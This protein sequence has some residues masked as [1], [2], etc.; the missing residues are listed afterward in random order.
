[1]H[2]QL[3]CK[4]NNITSSYWVWCFH[5]Q[6]G[7]LNSLTCRHLPAQIQLQKYQ[8]KVFNLFKANNKDTRTTSVRSGI[9]LVNF[10][11]ISKFFL[12]FLLLNLNRLR[13]NRVF[14]LLVSFLTLNKYFCFSLENSNY[15]CR[16][17]LTYPFLL[18]LLK[19]WSFVSLVTLTTHY[20]V[21]PFAPCNPLCGS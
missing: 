3:T 13:P 16:N 19:E 10:E 15:I 5:R 1:M 9:F 18:S 2:F 14:L 20:Y 7:K 17:R 4:H 21:N 11:H 12:M 6:Q 8:Q